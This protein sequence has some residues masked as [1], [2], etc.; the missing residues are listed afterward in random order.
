MGWAGPMTWRQYQAWNLWLIP[1][2]DTHPE[3]RKGWTL[4]AETKLAE[5][6]WDKLLG[7]PIRTTHKTT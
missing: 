5:S 1:P 2:P 6:R 7:K 4:E 3:L